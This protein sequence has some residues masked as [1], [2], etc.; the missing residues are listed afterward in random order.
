MSQALGTRVTADL[1]VE[2]QQFYAR[3]MR[4]LDSLQLVG[5]TET[6]TEDAVV[7]HV[8]RGERAVGREQML[9]GMRAALPRYAGV[10]VRH[11][12]DKLLLEPQGEDTVRVSY[13]TLVTRTDADGRVV[14]EPTFTVE[15]VLVRRDGE[16]FTKVRSIVR[17]TPP[18]LPT[19][20]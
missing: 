12:F 5:Y 15:D 9:A 3:Q 6:F 14:F 7:E 13:Y 16:L 19:L 18:P 10:A 1:Y 20:D 11:W 8:A 2:V 17:D 4:M